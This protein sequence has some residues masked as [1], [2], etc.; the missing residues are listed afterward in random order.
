MKYTIEQVE[1]FFK[2]AVDKMYES[3]E[4]PKE[5]RAIIADVKWEEVKGLL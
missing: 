4:Y 5:S 2:K 3:P 1:E